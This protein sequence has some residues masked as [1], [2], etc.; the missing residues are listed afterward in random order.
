[1]I[2]GGACDVPVIVTVL[3]DVAHPR[4]RLVATLLDDLEV[5][6]LNTRYGE[7]RDLEF[8][9]D[10]CALVERLVLCRRRCSQS[11]L[12]RVNGGARRRIMRKDA[13]LLGR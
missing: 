12:M 3:G 13:H 10:R 11:K 9:S 6:D 1:M 5:P 8:D 2:Q 4:K 7:V